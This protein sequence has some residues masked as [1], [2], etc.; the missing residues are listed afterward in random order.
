MDSRRYTKKLKTLVL[1]YAT[2]LSYAAVSELVLDTCKGATISSQQIWRLVKENALAISASQEAQIEAFTA[3]KAEIT[4]EKVDIYAQNAKEI[5]YLSDDVCVKEQKQVR[6]KIAKEGKSFCNTRISML[7]TTDGS[8]ETIVSG[9]ALDNVL[10]TKAVLWQNYGQ[11]HLPIVAITDGARS[12]KN[13]L[14][15]L[16]GSEV[17]HILDWYHLHKKVHQTLTMISHKQDKEQHS[18]ALLNYLWQGKTMDAIRYLQEIKAKN[19]ASKEMLITYLTKN[20]NT[21]IDYKKR[22]EI[23]KIIGSGRTEKANDIL[24]AKRQ[25]YKGMAWTPNGSLAIILTTAN[26]SATDLLQ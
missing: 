20:E 5:I 9:F 22:K 16:F 14:K 26:I 1:K 19:Q 12:L 7:Q 4:A 3:S 11:N 2:K 24:V 17:V 13:D 21:I 10:H 15:S 23:G 25:K 6:N 8:Y 18:T